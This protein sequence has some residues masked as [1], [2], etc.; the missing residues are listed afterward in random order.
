MKLFPYIVLGLL[1]SAGVAQAQPSYYQPYPP[2]PPAYQPQGYYSG[3]SYA[4]ATPGGYYQRQGSLV[5]GASL[6]LAAMSS[7]AGPVACSNCAFN[8]LGVEL[9]A[10]LGVMLTPRLALLGEMQADAQAVEIHEGGTKQLAQIML[11][12]SLKAWVTPRLWL[13]GGLG[14]AALSYDYDDAYGTASEPIGAGGAVFGAVGYELL[15]GRDYSLDVQARSIIGG[16][17]GIGERI[18]SSS[19]GLGFSW[20]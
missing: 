17:D 10:Q 8:P 15:S 16:Y 1:A 11:G 13:K 2:P 12:G 19:V 20:Y 5:I 3:P 14:V 4:T 9:D 7:E 6:G 18:V